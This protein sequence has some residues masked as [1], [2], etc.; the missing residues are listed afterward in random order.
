MSTSDSLSSAA[1][2]DDDDRESE[3]ERQLCP[4]ESCIGVL[5]PDLVCPECG[6]IAE[7]SPAPAAAAST[8]AARPSSGMGELATAE[9]A[10][11]RLCPDGSCI[12]I[13]GPDGSCKEC[14]RVSPE[15]TTDPRLQGLL[16]AD[17]DEGPASEAEPGDEFGDESGDEPAD[18]AGE[19]PA[20]RTR[21]TA[22]AS[23]DGFDE[24]D[25]FASRR[26]CP[27]GACTGIIG[28]AGTC[29]ECGTVE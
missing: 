28:S 2:P 27:D 11:R 21:A 20:S 7:A 12:G 19:T 24:P 15:V 4:D 3:S 6:A 23:D 18:E 13:I 16:R 9:F 29:N 25:D 22:P 10:S 8:R 1:Q 14:G 26:L 5:G 17:D